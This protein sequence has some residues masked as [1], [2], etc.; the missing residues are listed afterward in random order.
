MCVWFHSH[1]DVTET[2]CRVLIDD[3][4]SF[5]SDP[6]GATCHGCCCRCRESQQEQE[7]ATTR[8]LRD[9]KH[10]TSHGGKQD[11]RRMVRTDGAQIHPDLVQYDVSVVCVFVLNV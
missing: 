4:I 9:Q 10:L 8:S 2:L 5:V 11:R 7:E 6:R 1:S 3:V